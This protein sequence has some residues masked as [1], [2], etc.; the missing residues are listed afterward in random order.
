MTVLRDGKNVGTLDIVEASEDAIIRL[1][2]G[3]SLTEFFHQEKAAPHRPWNLAAADIALEVR[4]LTCRGTK[5]DPHAIVLDN[6]SFQLRRGEILGL[7]G[8]VGAGRTEVVRAIFGADGRDAGEVYVNGKLADIR[9]PLPRHPARHRLC[10]GGSQGAGPDPEP[11]GAHEPDAA[12]PGD[13][14][15]FR[16]CEP[17]RRGAGPRSI[18]ASGD[19]HPQPGSCWSET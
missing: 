1:M 14:D 10:A 6:I 3:R 9:S 18:S 11:G 8:L 2:V 5:V 7:A 16:L 4:G 13:S 15:P 12:Q 17:G 19:S